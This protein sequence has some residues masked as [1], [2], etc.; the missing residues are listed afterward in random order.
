MVYPC[1]SLA[2]KQHDALLAHNVEHGGLNLTVV[3]VD[4]NNNYVYIYI[5]IYT[6]IYQT[7]LEHFGSG[8][9]WIFGDHWSLPATDPTISVLGN[10]WRFPNKNGGI[11]V[12]HG[13]FVRISGIVFW[14]SY[15][16]QSPL[17]SFKKMGK[18]ST[19][20]IPM[21]WSFNNHLAVYTYDGLNLHSWLA[22]FWNSVAM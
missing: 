14:L 9:F 8:K 16:F 17:I 12:F 3:K 5:C 6:G 11:P 18:Y 2:G 22:N 4:T 13:T 1:L 20:N 7:C 10:L 19:C 21:C 15:L